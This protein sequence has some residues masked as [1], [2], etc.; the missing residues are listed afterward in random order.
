MQMIGAHAAVQIP[1]VGAKL[2]DM[3]NATDLAIRALNEFIDSWVG[4]AVRAHLYDDAA[5]DKMV[6]AIR[7]IAPAEKPTG[8]GYAIYGLK[9]ETRERKRAS[10]FEA[11]VI[12]AVFDQPPHASVIEERKAKPHYPP[13][14]VDHA[15]FIDYGICLLQQ[16]PT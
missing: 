1:S 14:Y 16:I 7:A 4:P 9:P 5:Y 3:T 10:G 8:I 6:A 11:V 12:S 2:A 15:K 13:G